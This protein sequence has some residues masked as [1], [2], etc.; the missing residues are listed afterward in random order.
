MPALTLEDRLPTLEHLPMQLTMV[1]CARLYRHQPAACTHLEGIL[2]EIFNEADEFLSL[3]STCEPSRGRRKSRSSDSMDQGVQGI[4][5]ET[6]AKEE[7]EM[8]GAGSPHAHRTAAIVYL[9]PVYTFIYSSISVYIVE[10][11]CVSE[12]REYNEKGTTRAEPEHDSD[13]REGDK[14]CERLPLKGTALEIAPEKDPVPN[15]QKNIGIL[16]GLKQDNLQR[17]TDSMGCS[18]QS[19]IK[20]ASQ[21]IR[22]GALISDGCPKLACPITEP[23]RI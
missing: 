6:E 3:L 2:Y 5:S 14:G 21:N 20:T 15:I 7:K 8:L 13:G 1:R 12:G 16:G 18:R 11:W 19:Q 23:L 9:C 10:N 4:G 22:K 17:N